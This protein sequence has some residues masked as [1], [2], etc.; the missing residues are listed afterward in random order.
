MHSVVCVYLPQMSSAMTVDVFTHRTNL[1]DLRLC[2]RFS[3][4]PFTVHSLIKAQGGRY[5]QA[6]RP[7]K[8]CW[9]LPMSAVETLNA[10]LR[11]TAGDEPTK[12]ARA[13][14]PFVTPSE[15]EE[16]GQRGSADTSSHADERR[17]P[18]AENLDGESQSQHDAEEEQEQPPKKRLR[19]THER[20]IN[21][22]RACQ[23]ETENLGEG[24]REMYHTC[25]EYD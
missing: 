5:R 11:R 6:K 25:T 24:H 19:V 3:Q 10:T 20:L 18:A 7:E 8:P 22:C 16:R 21:E 2:I 4:R 1:G 13:L 12:L 9:Y 17:E 23:Y 14:V 15:P